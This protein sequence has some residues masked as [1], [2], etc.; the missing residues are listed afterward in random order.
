MNTIL[1]TK[2]ESISIFFLFSL[3]IHEIFSYNSGIEK[4]KKELD[5]TNETKILKSIIK[6]GEKIPVIIN[7]EKF[8][9]GYNS[10]G[11]MCLY[12]DGCF[13]A[14]LVDSIYGEDLERQIKHLRK[15]TERTVVLKA[16]NVKNSNDDEVREVI[17]KELKKLKD[18]FIK[19]GELYEVEGRRVLRL[20]SP[21]TTR[22][23][24]FKRKGVLHAL[25]VEVSIGRY[26]GG[27]E[28]IRI[29][30][31]IKY[32]P[33]AEEEKVFDEK[34][35]ADLLCSAFT[36]DFK[37]FNQM[38]DKIFEKIKEIKFGRRLS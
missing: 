32:L 15:I 6:E 28:Y 12:K 7:E 1:Y 36:V 8:E 22:F 19:K 27:S 17:K 13:I 38:F 35:N 25:I 24:V 11:N 21:E 2:N 4:Q 34:I 5:M 20:L 29:R 30:G 33:T 9:V 31:D 18:H 14:R 26:F 10:R 3:D 23:I 16:K 37:C